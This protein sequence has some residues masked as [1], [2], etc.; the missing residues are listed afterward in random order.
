MALKNR[1]RRLVSHQITGVLTIAATRQPPV[2]VATERADD[3]VGR[4]V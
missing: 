2:I 1:E 4:L 3:G